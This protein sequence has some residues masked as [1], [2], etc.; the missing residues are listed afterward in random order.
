MAIRYVR[1]TDGNNADDGSTWA[2]A[3]ATLAGAAAIDTAGDTIYVSQAHNESTGAALNF[4]WAGSLASPTRVI[5][6]N[7]GAEPPTTPATSAIVTTTGT[8]AISLLTGVSY[9]YGIT[10]NCGS[11]TGSPNLSTGASTP[12]YAK[13]EACNFKLTAT[14]ALA[15]IA[16]GTGSYFI[17]CGFSF[18]NASQK[19][20][21]SGGI[22][23][24]HGGSVL[25]GSTQPTALF[26]HSSGVLIVEDFDLSNC[27]SS[28]N[29]ASVGTNYAMLLMR[30]CKLPASWSGSLVSGSP[31]ALS[32]FEMINCSAG[33][34]NYKYMRQTLFGTVNDETT[35]VRTTGGASDGTT[36]LSWKLVS[37]SNTV[38]PHSALELQN[39][40]KWNDT[41]G[42]SVT[43]TVEILTDGVTLK[44][45]EIWMEV[46]Y[47]GSSGQPLG[48][49]LKNS[50]AAIATASNQASSTESWTTTGLG[51]PVTQKLTATFTPNMVGFLLLRVCLA[52]PS[53]TVYVDPKVVLS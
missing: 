33:S 25:G 40:L 12:N 45:D 41:V 7:D 5:C 53:T 23:V 27:S 11:G 31:N 50:R 15:V 13:Y 9:Y 26:N 51:S 29:I 39:I 34:Q 30:D 32:V 24:I 4:A 8:N 19:I 49:F 52:K 36:P 10:F 22:V 2:L 38:F 48:T 37:G 21:T 18:A 17:N 14:G 47:L 35:I 28:V 1:S 20:Q 3:K 42:S 6:A 43:A 16:T 46:S 44:D